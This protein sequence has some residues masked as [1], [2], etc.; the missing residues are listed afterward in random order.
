MTVDECKKCTYFRNYENGAVLCGYEHNLVSMA[1]VFNQK[2][3]EHI[4]LACPIEIH[5]DLFHFR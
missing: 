5:G 1:I 2:T 4:L 3:N